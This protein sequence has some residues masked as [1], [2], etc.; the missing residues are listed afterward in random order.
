MNMGDLSNTLAGVIMVAGVAL[1]AATP[2]NA[3]AK[4][5]LSF[6]LFSFAGGITYVSS[7]TRTSLGGLSPTTPLLPAFGYQRTAPPT[8]YPPPCHLPDF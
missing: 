3:F 2:T 7:L 8:P 6:G 5:L 1:H 4:Y